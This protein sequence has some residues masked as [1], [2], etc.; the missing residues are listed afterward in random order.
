MSE[1]DMNSESKVEEAIPVAIHLEMNLT[2]YDLRHLDYCLTSYGVT[3]TV[4]I[5][6]PYNTLM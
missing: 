5:L 3:K 4:K 1:R 6:Y 2:Q